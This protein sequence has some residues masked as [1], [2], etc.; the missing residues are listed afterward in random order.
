MSLDN[1][2]DEHADGIVEAGKNPPVYFYVLFYGL[3]IWGV[4]FMAYYLFSGWSSSQEFAEKMA[5]HT[6]VQAAEAPAAAAGSFSDPA[7]A[8]GAASSSGSGSTVRSR[9]RSSGRQ[10]CVVPASTRNSV[11][12]GK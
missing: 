12:V 7:P 1:H 5:A 10:L 6:G 11:V 9:R 3:I 8:G 2:H 4:I